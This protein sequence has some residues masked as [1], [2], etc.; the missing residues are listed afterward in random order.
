MKKKNSFHIL[1]F[2][3]INNAE[4]QDVRIYTKKKKQE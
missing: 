4:I 2:I 3:E 1:K